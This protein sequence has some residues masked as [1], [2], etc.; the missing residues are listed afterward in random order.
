[1]RCAATPRGMSRLSRRNMSQYVAK[2]RSHQTLC[3]AVP[4]SA[5]RHRAA[6]QRNA[7]GVNEPLGYLSN[8]RMWWRVVYGT[9]QEC[10][11]RP[12]AWLGRGQRRRRSVLVV[13]CERSLKAIPSS[14][15]KSTAV[16]RRYCRPAR[17]RRSIWP[18]SH[19]ALRRYK[20]RCARFAMR[21][22]VYRAASS[23]WFTTL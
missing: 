16:W 2:V 15:C 11:W 4:R 22:G 9:R 13:C 21:A 20:P 10:V 14:R 8:A 1:M 19:S 7:V 5:V 3:V 18:H 23:L 6:P 12:S 17:P